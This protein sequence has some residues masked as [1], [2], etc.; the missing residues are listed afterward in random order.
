MGGKLKKLLIKKALS[1][2]DSLIAVSSYSKRVTLEK[3]PNLKIEVINNG[4]ETNRFTLTE[5][6]KKRLTNELRLITVGSMSYRK[7][8]HNVIRSIPYLKNH[9]D[10]ITYHIIGKSII[11]GELRDLTKSLGV[12]SNVKFHGY[13]SDE[14]ISK[15]MDESDIFIMLSENL[16][17]G[18]V[19]GFGIAILEA[20]YL[21]LPAIGSKNC[22]I[23]D[24]IKEGITGR[25]VD[26]NDNRTLLDATIDILSNYNSYSKDALN[27][28]K[29]ND[30]SIIIKKYMD[31]MN[32]LC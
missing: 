7:G 16:K 12:Q 2:F 13:V 18:E 1:N 11:E 32:K 3:C 24:A 14:K 15:V 29:K 22:G 19:E 31:H 5:N 17:N 20:N 23:E 6:I 8:Q 30:W 9:Y 21:G 26:I 27:W 4:L 10:N 28:S 25:L